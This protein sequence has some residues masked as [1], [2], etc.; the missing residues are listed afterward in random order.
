MD[1]DFFG[2]GIDGQGLLHNPLSLLVQAHHLLQFFVAEL[3]FAFSE[4]DLLLVVGDLGVEVGL[5][6]THVPQQLQILGGRVFE[7][8]LQIHQ[9]G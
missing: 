2:G 5:G 6:P 4:L 9:F 1:G 3:L 8:R 7:E